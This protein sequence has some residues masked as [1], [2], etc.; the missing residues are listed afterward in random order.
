M[1]GMSETFVTIALTVLIYMISWF[2]L[3]VLLKRR[4]VVDSAWGLG[5][6]LVGFV[7]YSMRNNDSIFTHITFVLVSAWG[8]RLFAHI[9]RRNWKKKED[10]RYAAMGSLN[11]FTSWVKVFFSV[12][13]LQGILMIAISTPVITIMAS[14]NQAIP[15]I[16]VVGS[17]V[18]LLGIVTEATADFQL[19][20][21]ITA[22]K[23]G[24]MQSGLWRYSRH[25]NYF[26][27]ITA[28]WGA[29]ILALSFNEWWGIIGA[30]VITIL[31]VKIS[32]I[33]LL[34]KRYAKDSEYQKYAKRTSK[35]IPLPVKGRENA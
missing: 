4:D 14:S 10:Y 8:L 2:V 1:Y 25:P 27:E 28:W 33:P 16:A 17:T 35:L 20:R 15:A 19:R 30:L 3:A 34:E 9:T 7:A 21:F 6:I 23:K 24:I 22:K 11:V 13:V 12:F 31:I 18:W 32:G 29:A 26:G 5:F